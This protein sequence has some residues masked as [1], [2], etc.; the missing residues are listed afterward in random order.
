MTDKLQCLTYNAKGLK[1]PQ[2]REG[3]FYWLKKK[4]VDIIC[5]TEAHCEEETLGKWK[6]EWEGD[7]VASHGTN[8]SRGTCFLIGKDSKIVVKKSEEDINGRYVILETTYGENSL[9][10]AGYY[11]PNQDDPSTLEEMLRKIDDMNS[12]HTIIM[13]DFNLVLDIDMDKKGGNPTT[14]WNCRKTLLHW[15]EINNMYDTWR[16]KHPDDK[17]FT[18][19]SNTK[20]KIFCRLDFFIASANIMNITNKC[21]IGPGI[22]SDHSYV[23]LEVA[24]P[25]A[26]RGRGFWKFDPS[27]LEDPKFNQEIIKTI[28]QTESDNKGTNPPLLWET[29]KCAI[30]GVCTIYSAKRRK[31]VN[32]TIKTLEEKV[33]E[34]VE[35]TTNQTGH[36]NNSQLDE[37]LNKAKKEL[38]ELIETKGRWAAA[39]HRTILHELDEKPS[40]FFINQ[41]KKASANK[42]LK[43]LIKDNGEEIT[44]QKGIL[45]EQKRFYDNLYRSSQ[46]T[47]QETEEERQLILDK[48]KKLPSPKVSPNNH[49][50]LCEEISEEELWKVINSCSDNKSPGSDGLN[51]NFYKAFWPNI[52]HLVISSINHSLK[53][54]HLSISQKQGII[55]LIP[56]PNKDTSRLKN[57][58]P[59]TLLNQDYKYLAKC[60]ANR[61]RKI[62][63]DIVG[64]DQTGFVPNRIIGTNIIK[65]QE[66]INIC[67]DLG[68]EGLMVC[69]DFEKAFDRIEWRFIQE[70][71]E[72]FNFPP[73]MIKWI[74]TLYTDITTCIINNGHI[75]R[76]FHPTRGVRQ[77]CPLSPIL[78]VITAELLA[79]K[80][81]ENPKILGLSTG[82]TTTKISQFAD[83]T[84]FY[85]SNNKTDLIE[86]FHTLEEFSLVS[87]LKV[88]KEKTEILPLGPT[89]PENLDKDISPYIRD[90]VKM[91]GINISRNKEEIIELNYKP[92][93]DKIEHTL[94]WWQYKG[95][96]IHG[97]IVVLKTLVISKLIYALSVIP[98]P[99]KKTLEDLQKK[100]Y[101]FVWD[102]KGDK[103]KR[104]TLIGDYIDGGYRMPDLITYSQALKVA[105]LKRVTQYSGT[106][107]DQIMR[108]LPTGNM[109]YFMSCEINFA[110]IPKKPCKGSIW[111]EILLQ[112]CLI[113]QSNN[114]KRKK[115]LEDL[116]EENIWWNS[117]IKVG[118]KVVEYKNWIKKGIVTTNQLYK[119][120]GEILGHKEFEGK[121]GLKVNMVEFY[122]ITTAVKK[123]WNNQVHQATTITETTRQPSILEMTN[124]KEKTSRVIYRHQIKIKC[125]KPER[126]K[127]KWEEDIGRPIEDPT[128]RSHLTKT[129]K[130]TISSKLLS[131][132]YR[133]NLRDIQY[134]SKLYKM[135]LSDSELCQFCGKETE[136]ILHL[137]WECPM[138]RKLWENLE[139]L[140]NIKIHI[141]LGLL[142]LENREN[143]NPGMAIKCLLTR[144]YIHICKCNNKTPSTYGQNSLIESHKRRDREISSRLNKIRKYRERWGE[145]EENK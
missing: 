53:T 98:S 116:L 51:N 11:G 28:E 69:I 140:H 49:T 61:C 17:K 76:F 8:N 56:K 30:R 72:Y 40:S 24:F 36:P 62:L 96:S 60:L 119:S 112:W 16:I 113:N 31:E 118:N 4:K 101:E 131:W 50:E 79:L 120:D 25:C 91:L 39:T 81:R 87:G 122:G 109:E 26:P 1:D 95:L 133:Y 136:R 141:P 93:L 125:I 45:E 137:Y 70:S 111:N 117:N 100:L 82:K 19:T 126:A 68:Q 107:S 27:L 110:D 41:G 63:P 32:N 138:I 85:L 12:G 10:L 127:N 75:S 43:K 55:S 139:L 132:L 9:T 130:L 65:A 77:G 103:I 20:P 58:R 37:D 44:G 128:W 29:V 97:K 6:K 54:G 15:M 78:F 104:D 35:E 57:W 99:P 64:P 21:T 102:G 89:N 144:Y 73:M 34:L 2:K 67:D 129:R 23:K 7:I 115:T 13:G 48:F 83:D 33:Q 18:W 84:V 47:I 46:N 90:Y 5:I 123:N 114:H 59:I 143:R 92:I 105:W 80:T 106:W 124:V 142:G 74:Q 42:T 66:M 38:E 134:N 145:V 71:L 86:V 94:T 121:Y 14:N 88:N 22:R 108:T 52:K 135:G 3:I